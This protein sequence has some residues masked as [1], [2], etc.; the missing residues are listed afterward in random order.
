MITVDDCDLISGMLAIA[1]V[2]IERHSYDDERYRK[3]RL[4]DCD[5]AINIVREHKKEM[6]K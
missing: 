2:K 1:R 4:D 3:G 6:R 5:R